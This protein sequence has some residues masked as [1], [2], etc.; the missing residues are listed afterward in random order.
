MTILE[1]T[2]E[3]EKLHSLQIKMITDAVESQYNLPEGAVYKNSRKRPIPEARQMSMSLIFILTKTR[4]IDIVKMF[5]CDH[6]NI[7]Y[8]MKTLRNLI[9]TNVPTHH[10]FMRVCN[11]LALDEN[12]INKILSK[13]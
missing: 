12:S 8:S 5:K 7:L 6:G 11:V 13:I 10:N 2:E 1:L 4:K 3:I 9:D